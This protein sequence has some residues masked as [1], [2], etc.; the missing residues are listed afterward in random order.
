MDKKTSRGTKKQC[1][2]LGCQNDYRYNV[3]MRFP[4][5][6]AQFGMSMQSPDAVERWMD[7]DGK[8]PRATNPSIVRGGRSTFALC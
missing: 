6:L 1:G 8:R 5:L 7:Q 4:L 3:K 2:G